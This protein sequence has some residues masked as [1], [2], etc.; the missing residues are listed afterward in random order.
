[1]IA[2][3]S[4]PLSSRALNRATLERQLLLRR[5]ALTAREAV[6]HLAGFRQ[7]HLKIF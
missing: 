2:V 6:G 1:M 7:Q 5:A 4:G 3:T